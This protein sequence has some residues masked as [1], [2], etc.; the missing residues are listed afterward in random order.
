MKQ[1]EAVTTIELTSKRYKK[2]K[3]VGIAL[4]FFGMVTAICAASSSSHTVL[5]M[6]FVLGSLLAVL[7]GICLTVTARFLAWWNHG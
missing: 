5:S 6:F 1:N 4:V 3:L 7:T 2:M